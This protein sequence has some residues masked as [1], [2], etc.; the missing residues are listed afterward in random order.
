MAGMKAYTFIWLYVIHRIKCRCVIYKYA[1]LEV[2]FKLFFVVILYTIII[3]GLF[4]DNFQF[5]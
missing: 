2:L 1:L 4:F 3:K 5:H